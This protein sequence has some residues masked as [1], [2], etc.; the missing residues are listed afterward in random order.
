MSAVVRGA[1]V[2]ASALALYEMANHPLVRVG[3]SMLAE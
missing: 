3:L 2:L 1:L